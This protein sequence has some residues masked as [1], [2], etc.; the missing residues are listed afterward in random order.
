MNINLEP[1]LHQRSSGQWCATAFGPLAILLSALLFLNCANFR[2]YFNAYF[3]AEKAYTK[4]VKLKKQRQKDN[5]TDTSLVSA[6]ERVKLE[7]AIEKAS[8]VLELYSGKP[9]KYLPKSLF[10]IGEA[11][12]RLGKC[13][14]AITKY[15]ELED[16][17]PNFANIETVRF[18][19]AQCLYLK[20]EYPGARRSLMDIINKS[21]NPQFRHMAMRYLAEMENSNNS[22]QEGLNA[23]EKLLKEPGITPR[24]KGEIHYECCHLSF[25]L[26]LWSRARA[27]GLAPEIS[28]LPVTFQFRAS[29]LSAVSYHNDNHKVQAYNELQSLLNN[30]DYIDYMPEVEVQLGEWSLEAGDEKKAFEIFTNVVTKYPRGRWSARAYFKM[31]EYTFTIKGN[32]KYALEFYD[33]AAVCGDSLEIALMARERS[34]SLRRLLELRAPKD[35]TADSLNSKNNFLIAELFLF[36]LDNVDSAISHLYKVS[37]QPASDSSLILKSTYARAFIYDEFSDS[38]QKADSLYEYV[39]EAFPNSDYAKQA[40]KNLGRVPSVKTSEDKAHEVFLKAERLFFEGRDLNDQVIPAYQQVID[41][42]PQTLYAAKAQFVIAMLHED[43]YYQG[44][45]SALYQAKLAHARVREA[46]KKS[47]YFPVS[48]DKLSSAGIKPGDDISRGVPVDTVD[49]NKNLKTRNN[50]PSADSGGKGPEDE[51]KFDEEEA[52]EETLDA[53]IDEY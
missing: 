30:G 14:Q 32:E 23:Y 38:S 16:A 46:Y 43:L 34:R 37:A 44:E 42:L 50:A 15:D 27:H 48:D 13:D 6:E 4:A 36:E 51:Y 35:S 2:A 5:P 21:G 8:K 33:S 3:N 12:S 22:P 9:N 45:D 11:Y 18:H 28:N 20:H 10:L 52:S 19:R 26:E 53:V 7:R 25:N 31:A 49:S 41:S 47:I 40:E 1:H 29:F 17:Y 24:F 39:L